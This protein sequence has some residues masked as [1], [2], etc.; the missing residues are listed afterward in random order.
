M[1]FTTAGRNEAANGVA[2][3]TTHLSL[4]SANPGNTGAN[5]LTGGTPAYARKVPVWAAPVNGRRN[6]TAAQQF[7][8]PAGSS[9]AY[10]GFWKNDNGTWSFLGYDE[11]RDAEG[12][13]VVETYGG[14]G[15][16]TLNAFIDFP[17]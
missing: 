9:V 5:E 2:A 3:A 7:D 6:L 11:L 10:V 4:H 8:V 15:V 13:P 12:E 14:Q 1:P 17:A 16:Y